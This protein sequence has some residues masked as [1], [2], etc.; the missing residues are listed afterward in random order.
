MNRETV[1]LQG[2]MY[3]DIVVTAGSWKDTDKLLDW[4]TR[5]GKRAGLHLTAHK[6]VVLRWRGSQRR[7][8]GDCG[9]AGKGPSVHILI[10]MIP[11]RGF[12][13]V[14][15]LSDK[16][17]KHLPWE[18]ARRGQIWKHTPAVLGNLNGIKTT[19]LFGFSRKLA[20]MKVAR[21]I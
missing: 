4:C 7:R 20:T 3:T 6:C 12:F 21:N 13:D 2:L 10:H 17:C 16:A 1:Y 5:L 14:C 9:S 19:Q 18:K 8:A 15:R 11:W